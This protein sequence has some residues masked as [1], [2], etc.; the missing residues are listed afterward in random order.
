MKEGR[1]CGEWRE[2]ECPYNYR[3]VFSDPLLVVW[4]GEWKTEGKCWVK[5]LTAGLAEI[6]HPESSQVF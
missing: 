2:V 4:M 6:F 5:N 1:V 3:G